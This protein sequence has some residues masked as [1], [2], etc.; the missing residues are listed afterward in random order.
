MCSVQF[1]IKRSNIFIIPALALLNF[2]R[3]AHFSLFLRRSFLLFPQKWRNFGVGEEGESFEKKWRGN[4]S[5][6]AAAVAIATGSHISEGI[7]S[8]WMNQVASTAHSFHFSMALGAHCTHSSRQQ[9]TRT[10]VDTFIFQQEIRNT[11]GSTFSFQSRRPWRTGQGR[12]GVFSKAVAAP[13]GSGL[14]QTDGH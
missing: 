13:L 11:K 5:L 4:N 10:I 8:E 7:T 1:N 3:V 12:T 9:Q 2:F 6:S 14:A